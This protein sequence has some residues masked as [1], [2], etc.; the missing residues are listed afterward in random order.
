[1]YNWKLPHINPLLNVWE[2]AVWQHIIFTED[3]DRTLWS[4]ISSRPAVF[5]KIHF[6]GN[7]RKRYLLRFSYIFSNVILVSNKKSGGKKL[8]LT[9]HL[10]D[11][12][13]ETLPATVLT[14]IKTD[15][16]AWKI[17]FQDTFG[18]EHTFGGPIND[19]ALNSS[20]KI[21]ELKHNLMQMCTT[22]SASR[23]F[24]YFLMSARS[25]ST[26]YRNALSSNISS[27]GTSYYIDGL[28]QSMHSVFAESLNLSQVKDSNSQI[29]TIHY[30]I[31]GIYPV[32]IHWWGVYA[33]LIL[34]W[35]IRCLNTLLSY[36]QH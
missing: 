31:A 23:L 24:H 35:G 12:G 20:S 9:Q 13:C 33:I 14:L 30:Y 15:D 2:K 18:S 7:K 26:P 25:G 17:N 36:T 22:F 11:F 28:M 21:V 6:C 3:M 34:C 32:L 10:S 1:M 16:A 5:L 19:R 27:Y 29:Y 8:T 4:I